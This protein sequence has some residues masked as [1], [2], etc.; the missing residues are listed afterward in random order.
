MRTYVRKFLCPPPNCFLRPP[1]FSSAHA[2][3]LPDESSL[4]RVNKLAS[5]DLASSA[6]QSEGGQDSLC[7]TRENFS[8][9][10]TTLND[11]EHLWEDG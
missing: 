2:R 9:I 4:P 1:F 11:V 3:T 7:V 8:I 6:N 5:K 10:S